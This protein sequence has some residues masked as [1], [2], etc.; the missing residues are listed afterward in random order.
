MSKRQDKI[1]ERK[2]EQTSF[3][4]ERK[5]QNMARFAAGL[6]MGKTILLEN[7]DQMS[8]EDVEV[9]KKEL[10]EN[11]KILDDYLEETKSAQSITKA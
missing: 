10:H 2:A 3:L 7:M 4:A 11:Q 1:A 5:K 8:P 9:L 6:E